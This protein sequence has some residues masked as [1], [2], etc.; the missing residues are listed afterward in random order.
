MRAKRSDL[1]PGATHVDEVVGPRVVCRIG[2]RVTP[3]LEKVAVGERSSRDRVAEM[4]VGVE[5]NVHWHSADIIGGLHRIA[6]VETLVARLAVRQ[7]DMFPVVEHFATTVALVGIV[8]IVA[9]LLSAVL[10]RTAAPLVAVF[11]ALGAALGPAGLGLADIGLDSPVL[12]ALATLALALVL[13]SDAVTIETSEVRARKRLVWRMVVPGTLVPAA[14]MAL[15]AWALLDVPAPAAAILGAA[16]ASTDPVMLRSA[17]RSRSM[18]ASARIALRLETGANDV[19]LLP[20]VVLAML[21]LAA[22]AQGRALSGQEVGR[23]VVSLFILGPVLGAF[24]GWL[25]ITALARIRDRYG[26]RRDYESL[27]ALGLA[28]SGFAAAEAVGGSGFLAAFAAGLMVAA[29]DIELCDCFLEYGEATAEMLLLLTFVAFGTS[30]IWTGFTVVDGR[31][32]LFAAIALT[33]RT[34]VLFPVLAGLGL[35]ERDRRLI[36]LFGPRGLSS[37]LLVLL[38]VFAGLPGT[39][40]LFTIAC[41]VVLLSVTLHG[42]GIALFLRRVHAAE[43]K[44]RVA[45]GEKPAL[46]PHSSLPTPPSEVP[47]RITIGEVEELRARGEPVVVVDARADRSYHA[48][49][50]QAKG[51]ARI[52]PA[53][54]VRSAQALRLSQHATLVIYCA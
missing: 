43:G 34:I 10:E 8:I 4:L 30:L 41:L 11:L 5:P 13:F 47:E 40:R 7:R 46:P 32:L 45:S 31:T 22:S 9:S 27:Y 35:A 50:I 21:V 18:P 44:G 24:V 53:D 29:Q 54:A 3:R 14:L 15:A 48:D 25:G 38:P 6:P 20:V 51:T 28:F 2:E 17:L 52:D 42:V 33:V 49:D 26:V 37:L 12:H 19:V 39:Q 36:A 1:E 16:L 23:A